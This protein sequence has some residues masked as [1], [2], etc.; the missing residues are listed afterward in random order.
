V[1]YM[2]PTIVYHWREQCQYCG[3]TGMVSEPNSCAFTNGG[4]TCPVCK[5]ERI[6]HRSEPFLLGIVRANSNTGIANP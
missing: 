2:N 1:I 6:V 3:G 4:I 5:G